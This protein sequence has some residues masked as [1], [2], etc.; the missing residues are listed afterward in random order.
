MNL[1]YA[2][3]LR[4]LKERPMTIEELKLLDKEGDTAE[5]VL[6]LVARGLVQALDGGLYQRNEEAL[7]R[8]ANR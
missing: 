4:V 3:I 6:C 7:E 8:E 5:S 1:P 2:T